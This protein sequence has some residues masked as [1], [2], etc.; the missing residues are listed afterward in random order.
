MKQLE[1]LVQLD[2]NRAV[3]IDEADMVHIQWHYLTIRLNMTGVLCLINFLETPCDECP[4]SSHFSLSGTP[5]DGY[6][7]WIQN[8]GLRLSFEDLRLFSELLKRAVQQIR[9]HGKIDSAEHL[10]DPLKLMCDVRMAPVYSAN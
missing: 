1:P 3:R 8:A 10:P 6:A 9:Q 2:A 5:D 7:L 4:V